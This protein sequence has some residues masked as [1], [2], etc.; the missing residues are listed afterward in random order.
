MDQD[1]VLQR[2]WQGAVFLGSAVVIGAVATWF[3]GWVGRRVRLPNGL[4][5][6]A[7]VLTPVALFYA[8]SLYLDTAG[9]VARAEVTRKDERISYA[10][11]IPGGWTRSYWAFVTFSAGDGPNGATLWLGETAFDA[12]HIGDRLDIRYVPAVPF[13]ARPA[14]D[15]T[16]GLIPWR[17]LTGAVVVAAVSAL[18][19]LGLRRRHPG[20]LALLAFVAIF[21]GVVAWVF[22]TPWDTPLA[23]P[24]RTTEAEV[25]QVRDI[26]RSSVSGR[27]TGSID[28]PQPWQLAEL[29]F[30]PEGRDQ[31][32]VAL[33]G[34]DVG[35]VPGLEAGRRVA[36][37]YS[38]SSPRDVRLVG[39]ERT[40]RWKEWLELGE[41]LAALA[42]IAAAFILGGKLLGAW[43]RR[44]LDRR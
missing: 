41:Y 35:S 22:P 4:V 11:R 33:D 12:L 2:L 18:A 32:V 5:L 20:V 28:A 21:L 43:W 8:G 3:T 27:S 17:V 6:L 7:Q 14:D 37:Q 40:Y 10:D 25:R 30:V 38:T 1:L 24:V 39:G 26:T 34:V 13:I 29:T 42:G 36:I 16:R 19:W 23:G 31:P 15:S 44:M 9:V